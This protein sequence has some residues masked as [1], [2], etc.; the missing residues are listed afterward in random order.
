MNTNCC[1]SLKFKKMLL[2]L[3]VNVFYVLLI[4]FQLSLFV[5]TNAERIEIL[6]SNVTTQQVKRHYLPLKSARSLITQGLVL[7]LISYKVPSPTNFL[8]KL[9][10]IVFS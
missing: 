8:N 4:L 7:N 9:A 10:E 2:K 3:N 6:M 1:F 5:L